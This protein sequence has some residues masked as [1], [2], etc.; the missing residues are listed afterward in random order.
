MMRKI[1]STVFILSIQFFRKKKLISLLHCS[2]KVF[3]A[4]IIY[5]YHEI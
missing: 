1:Q 3:D 4:K 5:H 2:A